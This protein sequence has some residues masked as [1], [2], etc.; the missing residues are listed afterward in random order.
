MSVSTLRA[1]KIGYISFIHNIYHS[2]ARVSNVVSIAQAFNLVHVPH[3]CIAVHFNGHI[4]TRF[5]VTIKHHRVRE[6]IVKY[7]CQLI[8]RVGPIAVQSEPLSTLLCGRYIESLVV[9]GSI[10]GEVQAV[11]GPVP[12]SAQHAY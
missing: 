4:P 2:K 12:I 3:S 8:A 5:V 9:T 6:T 10:A 11:L 1:D 7:D